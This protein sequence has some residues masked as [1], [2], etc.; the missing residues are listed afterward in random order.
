MIAL[1]I[2]V[3]CISAVRIAPDRVLTTPDEMEQTY[4]NWIHTLTLDH[5]RHIEQDLFY[6]GHPF[7][8]SIAEP[9]NEIWKTLES[10]FF[11]A[12][13]PHVRF[14]PNGGLEI[15]D[16]IYQNK[17]QII[18]QW[19]VDSFQPFVQTQAQGHVRAGLDARQAIST[20]IHTFTEAG[21]MAE[22]SLHCF[23]FKDFD[24]TRHVII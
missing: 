2:F 1:L 18:V 9:W 19:F 17:L 14:H 7:S 3:Q 13:A 16:S 5:R 8:E 15:P 21:Q 10:R 11:V 22:Y 24:L 20:W 12:W 6:D 23:I 4:T